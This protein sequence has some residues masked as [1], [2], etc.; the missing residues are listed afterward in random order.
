[1]TTPLRLLATGLACA[2]FLATSATVSAQRSVQ[3]SDLPPV[4]T[5]AT[6]TARHLATTQVGLGWFGLVHVDNAES[7]L[8]LPDGTERT[9]T[10][11]VNGSPAVSLAY[12]YRLNRVLSLGGVMSYQ[13]LRF[14]NFDYE[15]EQVDP[16]AQFNLNRTLLG[17]RVLFHYG[18]AEQVE[19]Y[20]GVRAGITVWGV[21]V[22]NFGDASVGGVDNVGRVTAGVT[23]QLTIIPFGVRA[24]VTEGLS[25]GGELGVGSPHILA[26]QIGY[27]F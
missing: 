25:L 9:G 2:T 10:A 26:A 21:R 16:D 15:G 8:T 11:S 13:S 12:D 3:L 6:T 22:R 5:R 27:R 24:Y 17:T 19:L 7:T 14:D 23:P 18:R 4:K 1:M 20:S